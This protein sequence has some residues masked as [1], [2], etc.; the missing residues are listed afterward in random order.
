MRA[1]SA[2]PARR[3]S[4]SGDA[5]TP[6]WSLPDEADDSW[7]LLPSASLPD[8]AFEP[9]AHAPS[10]PDTPPPAPPGVIA[11]DDLLAE[12]DS[13]IPGSESSNEPLGSQPLPLSLA[14]VLEATPPAI[15]P[16]PPVIPPVA[17][18]R[19]SVED[20][21]SLNRS[22]GLAPPPRPTD[23]GLGHSPPLAPFASSQARRVPSR[24]SLLVGAAVVVAIAIGLFVVTRDKPAPHTA[25]AA[26][27]AP[28]PEPDEP[29]DPPS[30]PEPAP[31][32]AVAP[33]PDATKPASKPATGSPARGSDAGSGAAPSLRRGAGQRARASRV[34]DE[35]GEPASKPRGGGDTERA[36]QDYAEGNQALF[37]GDAAGAIRAY[38]AALA[39]APG[40]V[41]GY[42]GLGL[43]YTQQGNKAKAIEAFE[44]YLAAAP[45]ANDVEL[46][47][48]RI[49]QLK[50]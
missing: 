47:K 12:V 34:T 29:S 25:Q 23:V 48:R 20:L 4:S 9:P 27:S 15:M 49:A 2:P 44:K 28:R 22:L 16:P 3:A 7:S 43:A 5:Q 8:R 46:I 32:P 14:P 50:Q 39:A 35:A 10:L 33:A 36:K 37:A 41:A 1:S 19:A 11:F 17:T 26:A 30:D 21:A 40:F 42:R 45:G 13:A 6:G 18:P 38:R 31:P 24:T